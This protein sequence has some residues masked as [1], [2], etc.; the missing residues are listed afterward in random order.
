MVRG[1]S[2]FQTMGGIVMDNE[3]MKNE[4]SNPTNDTKAR[5]IGAAVMFAITFCIAIYVLALCGVGTSGE[6]G[7]YISLAPLIAFV[8]AVIVALGASRH[9]TDVGIV[10]CITL[11]TIFLITCSA[12]ILVL[13]AFPFIVIIAMVLFFM[14]LLL[15]P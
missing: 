10:Q 12:L 6:G 2:P 7:E 11:A 8:I 9:F 15:Q 3:E 4:K 14:L 1:I 5:Y 13:V